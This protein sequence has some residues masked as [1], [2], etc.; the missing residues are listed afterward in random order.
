MKPHRMLLI[1]LLIAGYSASRLEAVERQQSFASIFPYDKGVL[2]AQSRAIL[3]ELY[4]KYNE[5]DMK[6]IAVKY[7]MGDNEASRESAEIEF[8]ILSTQKDLDRD[9]DW[10]RYEYQSVVLRVV[11]WGD[12]R[13]DCSLGF[14]RGTDSRYTGK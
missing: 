9:G 1:V 8:K 11:S 3:K 12:T 5:R 4:P 6:L 7:E 10:V 13:V 14:G 2:E